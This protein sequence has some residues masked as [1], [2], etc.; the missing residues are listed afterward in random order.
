MLLHRSHCLEEV[1]Q[2]QNM[3]SPTCLV[4]S[5]S[6]QRIL[7]FSFRS[8]GYTDDNRLLVKHDGCVNSTSVDRHFHSNVLS[9]FNVRMAV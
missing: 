2:V 7:S 6:G 9:H 1:V 8:N 5:V 3:Y 4:R